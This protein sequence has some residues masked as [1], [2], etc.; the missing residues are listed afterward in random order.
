M[1]TKS[2]KETANNLGA[3]LCNV[4]LADGFSG[5]PEGFRP[6]DVLPSCRSVAVLARRFNHS[7][8]RAASTSP[9]TVVRN[10]ISAGMNRLA[11][12]LADFLEAEGFEAVPVGSIGP[13]EY[14]AAS[15]KMRG[16]ISLKH[17]A[18]LAGMGKIGKNTLLVNDRYGN[19]IWLSAVLTSA[20]LKSDPP[21]AY[22]PCIPG[23]RLCLD[24]CP[25]RALDGV[26]IDQNACREYAF[27]AKNGGDWKIH[28]Y[29][30]RK[31]CPNCLGMKNPA[32]Q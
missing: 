16:T 1:D 31:I 8:L 23:C 9:Y 7:T 2:V 11:A 5:A 24:N 15:G 6:R 18:Q 19:M 14:D 17:A 28:C 22:E 25:V 32:E 26:S 30:C 27:G 13:D 3:H 10:D 20:E 4:A 29:T 12:G 21:A